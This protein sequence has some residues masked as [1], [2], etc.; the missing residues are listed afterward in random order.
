MKDLK[1]NRTEKAEVKEALSNDI[2][3]GLYYDFTLVNNE[4]GLTTAVKRMPITTIM[5]LLK[6]FETP[7]KKNLK[8]GLEVLGGHKNGRTT[9][10]KVTKM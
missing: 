5:Q 8:D 3:T 4:T 6:K 9:D 2:K 7:L 1:L 10:A